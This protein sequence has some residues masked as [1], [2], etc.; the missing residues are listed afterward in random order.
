MEIVSERFFDRLAV[1]GKIGFGEAYMAGDWT[2]DDLPGV[3]YAF[4]AGPI[5]PPAAPSTPDLDPASDSGARSAAGS[6][7][8]SPS[9]TPA[10][11]AFG[12]G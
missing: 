4:A 10:S 2:S 1:D 8:A 6:R 7:C 5:A 11:A 12:K 9:F 3:L